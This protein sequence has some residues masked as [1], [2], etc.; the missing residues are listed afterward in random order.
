M[1]SEL[2][3]LPASNMIFSFKFDISES[4]K[5]SFEWQFLYCLSH[6]EPLGSIYYYPVLP[7]LRNYR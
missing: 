3:F 2:L 5:L 4:A 6:N 7:I 1:P